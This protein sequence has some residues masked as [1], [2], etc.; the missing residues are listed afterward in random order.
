M[1]SVNKKEKEILVE[2]NICITSTKGKNCFRCFS[3]KEE[4]CIKCLKTYLLGTTQDPH[5]LHCRSAIDYNTFIEKFDKTWRL[6]VYK[7]HREKILWE[8]EQ[9]LFPATVG[10]IDLKKRYTEAT[11]KRQHYYTLYNLSAIRK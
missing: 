10:Y 8:R 6:G 4:Y 11:T 3:C 5:C 9:S 1:L 2:C 7:E